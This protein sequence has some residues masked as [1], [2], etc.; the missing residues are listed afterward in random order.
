MRPPQAQLL[1][2]NSPEDRDQGLNMNLKVCLLGQAFFHKAYFKCGSDTPVF[3]G[4]VVD[5]DK[6]VFGVDLKTAAEIVL[7]RGDRALL[8]S[9]GSAGEDREIYYHEII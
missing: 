6:H 8:L 7:Y 4:R 2:G 9:G 1:S 3:P 5:N